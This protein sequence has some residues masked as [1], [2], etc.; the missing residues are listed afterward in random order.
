M[1]HTSS[2][3]NEHLTNTLLKLMI[4]N[5]IDA[6][7]NFELISSFVKSNQPNNANKPELNSQQLERRNQTT[8][9]VFASVNKV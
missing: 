3:L 2:K 1:A 4:E 7:N 6:Y 8:S 5:P 9:K